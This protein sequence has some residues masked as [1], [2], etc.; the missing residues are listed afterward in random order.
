M[1]Q[2]SKMD[3]NTGQS[4]IQDSMRKIIFKLSY[5]ETTQPFEKKLLKYWMKCFFECPILN[6]VFFVSQKFKMATTAGYISTGESLR[7]LNKI[8]DHKSS[9]SYLTKT[10]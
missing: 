10:V 8:F 7:K 3:T 5:S 9:K 6:Y 4:L 1:D 2:K